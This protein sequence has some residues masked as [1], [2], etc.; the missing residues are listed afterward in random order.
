M[1]SDVYCIALYSLQAARHNAMRMYSRLYSDIQRIH[2]LFSTM[3]YTAVNRP[4]LVGDKDRGAVGA[5]HRAP[6][7]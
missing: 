5:V 7:A 6:A 3:I 1:Y 2:R 4:H